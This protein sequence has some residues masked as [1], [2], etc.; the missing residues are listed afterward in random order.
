MRSSACHCLLWAARLVPASEE[1]ISACEILSS[2]E[3]CWSAV[4]LFGL[5][6]YIIL[7]S[8]CRRRRR[9]KKSSH[10]CATLRGEGLI[11]REEAT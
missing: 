9:R 5:Q 2:P 11:P 6:G 8:L 1:Q 10:K 4:G 3:T 7:A